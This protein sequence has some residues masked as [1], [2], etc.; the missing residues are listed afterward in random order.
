MRGEQDI[1]KLLERFSSRPAPGVLREKVIQ[2]SRREAEARR[3]LTPAWRW[4][5]APSSILLACFILADWRVSAAEQDRL[6]SLL[7]LPGAR[8][9]SPEKAADEKAREVLAYL[10]DLDS[11]SQLALRQSFLK[12]RRAAGGSQKSA[13]HLTEGIN[14]F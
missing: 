14:E 12:N 4:A 6:S 7:S 10:P 13:V 5:L 8:A 9:V 1:E 2:A 3:I 11:A